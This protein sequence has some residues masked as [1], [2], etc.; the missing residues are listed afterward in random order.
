MIRHLPVVLI[1]C[2]FLK[3]GAVSSSASADDRLDS[4]LPAALAWVAAIDAGRYDDSYSTAGTALHEK[5]KQDQWDAVL[6]TLRPAWGNV[7]SRKA[8]SHEYKPDGYEGANGEFMVI[9]YATSFKKL[10]SGVEVVVLHWEDGQWR[11]V[12]YNAGPKPTVQDDQPPPQS[13]SQTEVQTE[14]LPAHP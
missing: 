1:A 14:T 12:G 2:C 10:D 3:L 11:G 6:K 13:Q 5:V 7:V 8:I 4:A 9:T